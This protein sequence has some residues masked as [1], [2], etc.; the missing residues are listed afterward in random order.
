ML[1]V[2]QG[3]QP[4]NV[5]PE[6]FGEGLGL[7]LTQFRELGGDLLHRAMPLAELLARGRQVRLRWPG[8]VPVVH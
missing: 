6:Q 7:G 8:D 1:T 3:G 4:L 5:Y 2:G